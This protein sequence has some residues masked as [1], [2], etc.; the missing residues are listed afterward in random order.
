MK[1]QE[2]ILSKNN[3][4]MTILKKS[5]KRKHLM[6]D[7]KDSDLRGK[8]FAIEG[9]LRLHL[10][11]NQFSKKDEQKANLLLL[12][13]KEFE[14]ILG[15][16]GLNLELYKLTPTKNIPS[17]INKFTEVFLKEYIVKHWAV[18]K[19]DQLNKSILELDFPKN[20]N[21]KLKK[22]LVKEINRINKKSKL[23]KDLIISK[24]YSHNNL[25]N[26]F[27][28]WRR[29][30]R[31]ISIYLQVYSQQVFLK[32][33]KKDIKSILY[34]KYKNNIFAKFD[35]SSK[36]ININKTQY[37]I[38]SD[39]IEDIGKIKTQGEY[40]IYINKPYHT[41]EKDAENI[42]NI[43]KKSQVLKKLLKK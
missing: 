15:M 27:H 21:K 43:F 19:F 14:D 1:S 12:E 32:E 17:N 13:Y 39:F 23:L 4:I 36:D 3:E 30:L 20:N 6:K 5:L 34:K 16:V 41:L 28:E 9:V 37:L 2:I 7:F 38:L 18:N 10:K 31:W 8:L 25:E 11:T 40:K 35:G 33:K 29:A 26:G 24:K 42:Y 22:M